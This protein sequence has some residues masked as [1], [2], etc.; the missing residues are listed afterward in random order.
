MRVALLAVVVLNL[1][2]C[3]FHLRGTG[4]H[5]VLPPALESVRVASTGPLEYDPLAEAVREALARAG[6]RVTA[7]EDAPAVVLLGEQVATRVASVRGTTGKAAE[8]LLLYSA[9]FRVDGPR[10]IAPQ[11]V[12][13]QRDYSFDPE[14]VLAK[15]QQE[16]ELLASMRQEAAQQIVR[17]LARLLASDAR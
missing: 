13:L 5:A 7:A 4:G 15:E 1:S 12:R 16:Q 9:A 2:A 3:G 11:T 6:A 8:Y 14:Q 10:P 17:R